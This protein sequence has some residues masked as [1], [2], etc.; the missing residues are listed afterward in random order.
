M[1]WWRS[2]ATWS[3]GRALLLDLH[4][5]LSIWLSRCCC[6]FHKTPISVL[7][8]IEMACSLPLFYLCIKSFYLVFSRLLFALAL[9]RLILGSDGA[10]A[11][12]K[13]RLGQ[14]YSRLSPST[15]NNPPLCGFPSRESILSSCPSC[16][17]SSSNYVSVLKGS[18][19]HNN[20]YILTVIIYIIKYKFIN[21][22]MSYIKI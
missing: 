17:I 4:H 5:T 22:N 12:F 7:K 11:G 19:N 10:R 6:F 2:C 13:S 8:S 15:H 18:S 16:L 20:I 21:S 9:A 3:I 1:R 14:A